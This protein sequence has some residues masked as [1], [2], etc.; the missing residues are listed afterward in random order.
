MSKLIKIAALNT[1]VAKENFVYIKELIKNNNIV[2]LS[3]PWLSNLE[4]FLINNLCEENESIFFSSPME[5]LNSIGRPWGGLC[6]IIKKEIKII[7][8]ENIEEGISILNISVNNEKYSIIGVYLKYNSHKIEN[9]IRYDSQ[10]SLLEQKLKDLRIRKENIMIIGDFNGDIFRKKYNNDNKLLQ[11]IN[12]LHL[13]NVCTIN[14]KT[15][16]KIKINTIWKEGDD[17]EERIEQC[18]KNLCECFINAHNEIIKA[19]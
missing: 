15:K 17:A 7:N 16:Q 3:E 19:R 5:T 1:A 8:V 2:F 13:K 18:Y 11:W 14:N 9:I 12:K 6:C 10:L 4:K